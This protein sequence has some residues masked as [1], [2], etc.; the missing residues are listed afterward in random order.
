MELFAILS[1]GYSDKEYKYLPREKQPEANS[2][3]ER[4]IDSGR[5][6]MVS[7]L[8]EHEIHRKSHASAAPFVPLQ[9]DPDDI[10][11]YDEEYPKLEEIKTRPFANMSRATFERSLASGHMYMVRQMV[12]HL[13]VYSHRERTRLSYPLPSA[14]IGTVLSLI[15]I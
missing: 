9:I 10:I 2:T 7:R 5:R 6:A 13:P 14:R 3:F 11:E 1:G 15:H 12:N 8:A 4:V